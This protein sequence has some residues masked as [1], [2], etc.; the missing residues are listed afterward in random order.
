[1]NR[2]ITIFWLAGES[3]GDLHCE[4]IMKA[5][6]K[7]GKRYKHV[8]IGGPKMQAQGLKA[9]FP[10]DRFAVMGFVEV[11]AHLAFFLKVEQR[12]KRLFEEAKPDLVILADYPGLNLRI[13]H[14][15]DEY[16]I[17]VLYY[18]VPQFWAWKHERV[19]KLKAN[20]RHCACILPFEEDL[21]SIHNID[22]T[23]VGHPIAEE[24]EQKMD[25]DTFARFFHLN[26]G[27]KWL[28]FFP[29]SRNS[30]AKKMLPTFLKA[31]RKW[32]PNQYEILVSKSHGVKHQLF[33]DLVSNTGMP[34]LN[35]IDGYNYD[36]MKHC[37]ALVCTSGTVTLEAAYI[38]TP[39]VICYKANPFSYLIGKHLIRVSRIGLP[40]IILDNDVL[41]ELVQ[42]D[43]TQENINTKLLEILP[44]SPRREVVLLELRKL[45][46]MLSGKKPSV[47]MPKIIQHML[48]T[49]G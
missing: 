31:A 7:D 6:A 8:G 13:A 49:Y 37:D 32:D 16:R 33:M 29:G 30:E 24:I 26:A 21:L 39:S 35:I 22:C 28:G 46:A 47:E 43:M 40:N 36:M 11:L 23:Y 1:M 3:S 18:I 20:V 19:F 4:L 27:R 5:L 9:L 2:L 38:G 12:I 15:A 14:L 42:Q 34:N 25:R 41:P 45:R 44:G 10:F 48:S 17:P